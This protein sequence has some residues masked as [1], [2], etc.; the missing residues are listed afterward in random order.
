MRLKAPGQNCPDRVPA[1]ENTP[2]CHATCAKYQAF[3]NQSKEESIERLRKMK[4]EN[5]LSPQK[6]RSIYRAMRWK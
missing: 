2:S 4:A 3:T 5:T 6:K 1:G